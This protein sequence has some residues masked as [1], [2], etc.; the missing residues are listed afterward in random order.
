MA[1]AI[2]LISGVLRGG[3]QLSGPRKNNFPSSAADASRLAALLV[4]RILPVWPSANSL[5]RCDRL[6]AQPDTR[7]LAVAGSSVT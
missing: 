2:P 7:V 3:G 1:E 6:L 4:G 5:I